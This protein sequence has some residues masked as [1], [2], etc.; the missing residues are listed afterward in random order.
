MDSQ[1]FCF[2][3]DQFDPEERIPRQNSFYATEVAPVGIQNHAYFPAPGKN[4]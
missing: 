1:Y 4:N 3:D 2:L